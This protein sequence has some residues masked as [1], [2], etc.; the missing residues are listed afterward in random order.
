MMDAGTLEKVESFVARTLD[1]EMSVYATRAERVAMRAGLHNACIIMDI[2]RMSM[3][4]KR[5]RNSGESKAEECLREAADLIFSI[6]ERIDVPS[7]YQTEG[8]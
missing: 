5:R 3:T 1:A 8:E 6:R 7:A 4:A 2:I